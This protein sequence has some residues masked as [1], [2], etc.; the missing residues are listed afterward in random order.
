MSSLVAFEF[1]SVPSSARVLL[2]SKI[3]ALVERPLASSVLL[4]F[5]S[6]MFR[7]ERCFTLSGSCI[8]NSFIVS[9]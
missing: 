8:S 3:F 2:I 1:K 6:V 7:T 9:P 5:R 4:A